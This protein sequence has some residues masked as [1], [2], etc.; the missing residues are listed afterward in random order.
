MA[1]PLESSAH[2]TLSV[3]GRRPSACSRPDL[4][5]RRLLL[6]GDGVLQTC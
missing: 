6:P 1:A 2:L 3:Y 5:D 4:A